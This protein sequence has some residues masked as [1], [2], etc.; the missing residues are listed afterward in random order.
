MHDQANF[1]FQWRHKRVSIIIP[2]ISGDAAI[3]ANCLFR[4]SSTVRKDKNAKL[5]NKVVQTTRTIKAAVSTF[6][7]HR[8][9]RRASKELGSN[10]K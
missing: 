7:Q 3:T 10:R 4:A 6:T 5:K 2:T 1:I 9:T 8:P